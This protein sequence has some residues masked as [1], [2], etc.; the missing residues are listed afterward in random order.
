LA[1]VPQIDVASDG[2][3][4]SRLV[5]GLWRL[6]E[7]EMSPNDLVGWIEECLGMGITTFDH[8]DIYGDYLCERLFGEA[9][10]A[11]PSLREKMQI[12]TKCGIKLVSRYRPENAVQY[13]DTSK[14]HII[15]AVEN[16][17]EMLRTDHIDLLMIH[18]PDPL[19][20]ADEVAEAF[21]ELRRA[22][23]A[24]HF[25][26]SNFT[27][28][29]YELLSSRL[30]YPLVTNQVEIS[31]M[32]LAALHDGTV[33]QCQQYRISPMAWSP[34][35]GGELFQSDSEK[36]VRVRR[37]L[38]AVGDELGGVSV[39]QVALA[40]IFTHPARIL[41]VLGTG[42]IDR[43]KAAAAAEGLSLSRQQWFAV[44]IASMGHEV[45]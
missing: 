45:P 14:A 40:W 39:D 30:D 26:V 38:T 12:V 43:I 19:M 1:L 9:L 2:P 16:S 42:K 10:A 7:W 41:P 20:N 31:V 11:K 37:A 32:N 36:A 3:R 28:W 17:L 33:D 29:Q 13:Y 5:A 8:A 44:W 18:R 6:A 27:P 24:L 15:G 25:G 34:F 21:D 23:K 35:G 4:F 22:G